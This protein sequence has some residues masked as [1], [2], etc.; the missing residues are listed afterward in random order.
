MDSNFKI[1]QDFV[2]V[3]LN[4]GANSNFLTKCIKNQFLNFILLDCEKSNYLKSKNLFKNIIKIIIYSLFKK[5]YFDYK[6]KYVVCHFHGEGDNVTYDLRFLTSCIDSDFLILKSNYKS[7][8]NNE[9]NIYSEPNIFVSIYCII[10]ALYYSLILSIINPLKN[11]DRILLIKPIVDIFI[12]DYI[13]RKYL[14][15][16]IIKGGLSM[17]DSW[18][19]DT[20]FINRLNNV[21][22][23]TICLPHSF[24]I[25]DQV[26]NFYMPFESK[27][28]IL[29]DRLER[30]FT[31]NLI[32][33][34][35]K[36]FI[37]L[38]PRYKDFSLIK[39]IKAKKNSLLL[40]IRKIE[41]WGLDQAINQINH[42]LMSNVLE[43]IIIRPH[44]GDND[45]IKYLNKHEIKDVRVKIEKNPN[46][47]SLLENLRECQNVV[48]TGSSVGYEALI[49]GRTLYEYN[50][51]GIDSIF[52]KNSYSN[53]IWLNKP[54]ELVEN[55][56]IYDPGHQDGNINKI[57]NKI[58]NIN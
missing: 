29:K 21:R 51:N 14:K 17:M 5:K 36:I 23:P 35:Q 28:L 25:S 47:D 24:I 6:K 19:I 55:K 26:K 2:N 34:R 3:N 43:L 44:P 48:M 4:K 16:K 39:K 46:R 1:Y 7:L 33:E 10:K 41:R 42:I 12:T 40:C 53:S 8:K 38:Y 22:I 37:G 15:K 52:L 13:I 54:F 32:Q 45:L 31:V 18:H 30:D 49:S 58:F 56:I 11:Y 57:C 20:V 50:I 9:I 27:F